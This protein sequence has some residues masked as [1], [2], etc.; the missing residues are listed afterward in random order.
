MR[1][2]L[3]DLF[4]QMYTR[5]QQVATHAGFADF[6]AYSFAAKCRFD[7]TP[8]DVTRFHEAV[9]AEVVPAVARILELQRWRAWTSTSSAHGIS[10]WTRQP[11]AA[12]AVP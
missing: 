9:E 7:Y 11:A 2:Q 4:D 1:V 10:T 6:E 3:A 8:D 12:P 5:R